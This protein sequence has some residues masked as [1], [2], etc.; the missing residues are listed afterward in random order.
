[1][2]R[3]DISIIGAGV[4]G[5]AIAQHLASPQRQLMIL[6][7]HS[8][9]GHETSSRNSEV[10]HAGIYYP[11]GSL[12]A[13]LCVTGKQKLYEYCEKNNIPHQRIGKIIVATKSEEDPI[14]Q[15]ILKK[16]ENNGVHDLQWQSQKQLQ[17]IEPE[18]QGTLAL[19]SPS[20]GI[21]DSHMLMRSFLGKA[22][23]QGAH[24]VAQA[25]VT[26]IE[27]VTDGF[28]VRV[29]N[30][31]EVYTFHTRI[32]INSAGLHA[33]KVSHTIEGLASETIPPIYLCKGNYFSMNGKSPFAHLIY[34]V[35]EK[36]GLGIH[37][38]LDLAGQTRFG[39]DTEYIDQENYEVSLDNLPKY[40]QAIRRYYPNLPDHALQPGYVGIRPKLQAPGESFQDF[41]IQDQSDHQIP[42]LIQLYGIES[43]GLTSSLAIAESVHKLLDL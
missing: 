2:D 43:P 18:V 12:K 36:A 28:I 29:S 21:I 17:Q 26:H 25:H 22:E 42:G 23:N 34:P 8:S 27:I 10:I 20:T 3:V 5:L 19:L 30:G 1:M 15:S 24:F 35:P 16:A 13:T 9:F 37:A 7:Q 41:V 38:T 33:Q 6:E 4:V 40:Y 39:P 14:L 11:Q 31:G 32:L